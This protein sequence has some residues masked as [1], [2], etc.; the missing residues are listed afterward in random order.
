MLRS[1]R[2]DLEAGSVIEDPPHNNLDD[3]AD[4]CRDR[5]TPLGW[6]GSVSRGTAAA[7]EVSRRPDLS[8]VRSAAADPWPSGTVLTGVVDLP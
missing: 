4:C 3:V 7:G 5:L 2:G 8:G 1:Q 6:A